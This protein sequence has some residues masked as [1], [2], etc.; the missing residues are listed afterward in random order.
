MR[1]ALGELVCLVQFGKDSDK[2]VILHANAAWTR[3]TGSRIEVPQTDEDIDKANLPSFWDFFKTGGDKKSAGFQAVPND[4]AGG[5]PRVFA[6]SGTLSTSSLEQPASCRFV[7]VSQPLDMAAAAV[8]TT[9]SSQT[10][11]DAHSR[12]NFLYFVIMVTEGSLLSGLAR[13]EVDSRQSTPNTVSPTSYLPGR[14]EVSPDNTPVNAV[15]SGSSTAGSGRGSFTVAPSAN[16]LRSIMKVNTS[17]APFLDVT[18]V[19]KVSEGTFG[20]VYMAEWKGSLAALRV[21]ELE[22]GSKRN[23]VQ[24]N[25]EAHLAR[26]LT[27][28]NVVELLMH[29]IK[30]KD[31]KVARVVSDADAD[32]TIK[33]ASANV[34]KVRKFWIVQE[35]CDKGT[36]ERRFF[37]RSWAPSETPEL[38]SVYTEISLAGAYLHSQGIILGTITAKKVLLKSDPCPKGYVSK[39]SDVGLEYC[40]LEGAE[41]SRLYEDHRLVTHAAPELFNSMAGIRLSCQ[42]DVY[43]SAVMVWTLVHGELPCRNC[44]AAQ[45]VM[46]ALS[47]NHLQLPEDVPTCIRKC[48]DFSTAMKPKSRPAFE[49]L[50]RLLRMV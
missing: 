7:P 5:R 33:L 47:G 31:E 23:G 40:D 3:V 36:L 17:R 38:V 50:V 34:V 49:H 24:A 39:V 44:T 29:N 42:A 9:T 30:M 46:R 21:L 35:W 8:R 28:P 20:K 48:F 11:A 43:A 22:D 10:T 18:L 15:L 16:S 2:C 19:S 1:E 32:T 6:M 41:A 4:V 26:T 27:H 45:V 14:G 37:N 12:G 13:E 25:L